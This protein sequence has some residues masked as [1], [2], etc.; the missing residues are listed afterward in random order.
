MKTNLLFTIA[1]CVVFS[2]IA[3]SINAQTDPGTDNLTHLWDFEDGTTGDAIGG[4]T[5]VL[6]QGATV[7]NGDL[8]MADTGQYMEM[9]GALI[10]INSYTEVTIAAW[11][12]SG[13]LANAGWS[14]LWYFGGQEGCVGGAGMFFTAAR[15]DDKCR[16]A[17]SCGNLTEPWTVETGVD[18]LPELDSGN[19]HLATTYVN[20]TDIGLY[21]DEAFVGSAAL[22]GDNSLANLST[23]RAYLSKGGYCGDPEWIGRIHEVRIYDRVLTADEVSFLYHNGPFPVGIEETKVSFSPKIYSANGLIYIENLENHILNSVEIFDMVGKMVYK[24]DV[25]SEVINPNLPS[26]LYIV[27]LQGDNLNYQTKISIR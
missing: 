12:T 16:A 10:A 20:A 22:E 6:M 3:G 17:I 8:Y 26:N 24:T 13:Y 2:V 25:F 23:D 1:L 15:A 14:M 18:Y 19:L 5:G 21:I 7:D 27:R 9:P 11:F 4:A